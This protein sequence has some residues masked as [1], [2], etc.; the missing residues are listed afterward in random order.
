[1][2]LAASCNIVFNGGALDW[3][4]RLSRP[5]S[6]RECVGSDVIIVTAYSPD[7]ATNFTNLGAL[8]DFTNVVSRFTK[9]KV[10]SKRNFACMSPALLLEDFSR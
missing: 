3:N 4:D 1:M 8:Y 9:N 7:F 6:W 2:P 10:S 5:I